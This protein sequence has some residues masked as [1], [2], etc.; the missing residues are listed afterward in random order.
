[1]SPIGHCSDGRMVSAP[2]Q[3]PPVGGTLGLS[4]GAE[5]PWFLFFGLIRGKIT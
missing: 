2:E 1:M 4:S 3:L 5:R